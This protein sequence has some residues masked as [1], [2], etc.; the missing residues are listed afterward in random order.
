MLSWMLMRHVWSLEV[1]FNTWQSQDVT[2][3]PGWLLMDHHTAAEL[4]H[5]GNL[6]ALLAAAMHAG[7][8]TECQ[9]CRQDSSAWH[10]VH[11]SCSTVMTHCPTLPSHQ[12]TQHHHHDTL[13]TSHS[14]HWW[15]IVHL[16]NL[17]DTA[18]L[19]PHQLMADTL[20][21]QQSVSHSVNQSVSLKWS[22]KVQYNYNNIT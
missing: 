16:I 3:I 17:H 10:T 19:S 14:Q 4:H 22:A 15:H 5:L 6:L 11:F 20:V 13:I 7:K 8:V 12:P 21:W 18:Q 1:L 2:N 9:Q